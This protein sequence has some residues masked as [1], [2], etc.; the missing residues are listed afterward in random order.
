MSIPT[1]ICRDAGALLRPAA[2]RSACLAQAMTAAIL[3]AL[4]PLA[5][6]ASLAN[7]AGAA[8]LVSAQTV[9]GAQLSQ[10]GA[11]SFAH[12]VN[13]VPV[14]GGNSAGP[15]GSSSVGG[16][17]LSAWADTTQID[18]SVLA[19]AR[20]EADLAF[21]RLR[22]YAEAG[23]SGVPGF[24]SSQGFGRAQWIDTI[25]FNNTTAGNVE[26]DFFWQTDGSITTM[27]P[28][29]R[30]FVTSSITLSRNNLNP[31]LIGMKDANGNYAAHLGGAQYKYYGVDANGGDGFAFAPHGG[32][33][34]GAW[35]TSLGAG[36]SGLIE[37]T[38]I[39]PVGLASIDIDAFL[40]VDCRSGV[41]CDFG[42]TAT[43][44][45]GAL[46][47]GLSWTSESGVFLTGREPPPGAVPE[48]ATLALL[49]LGLVGLGIARRRCA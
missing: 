14:N 40:E 16:N 13:G 4:V 19:T 30:R 32:N 18:G 1:A 9:S 22:A 35:R 6:G 12:I 37:A 3:R 36:E 43:F 44:G 41:I 25:T 23:V 42:H 15:G 10:Q 39:I 49:T 46:P 33:P 17:A 45:F 28:D 47:A 11:S 21:G 31:S 26:L 20:V 8:P 48:P 38:L 29:S 24:F 7:S 34:D 27:R 2:T 5:V